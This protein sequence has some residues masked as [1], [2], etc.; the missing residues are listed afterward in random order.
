MTLPKGKAKIAD[1]EMRKIQPERCVTALCPHALAMIKEAAKIILILSN[2]SAISI[3]LI[4][5]G[6]KVSNN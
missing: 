6:N 4:V 3:V 5:N 1:E 2:I